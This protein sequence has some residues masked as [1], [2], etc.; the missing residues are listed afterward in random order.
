MSVLFL[1]IHLYIK[2]SSL[3]CFRNFVLRIID[4]KVGF[5][6]RDCTENTKYLGSREIET[7]VVVG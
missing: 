7:G 2:S 6:P 4:F 3:L 1:F 5:S